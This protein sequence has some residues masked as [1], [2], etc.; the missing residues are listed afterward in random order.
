M[1]VSL[2]IYTHFTHKLNKYRR[3]NTGLKV[4]FKFSALE[5]IDFDWELLKCLYLY[6][7]VFV[8]ESENDRKLL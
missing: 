8:I 2:S 5:N 3:L 4:F 6:F 1:F 7:P